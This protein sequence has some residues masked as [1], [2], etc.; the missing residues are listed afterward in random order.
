VKERD[1]LDV[2]RGVCSMTRDETT[3]LDEIIGDFDPT[4][5][6]EKTRLT[7]QIAIWLTEEDKA[8]YDK[9]NRKREF[10]KVARK[11]LQAVMKR[12]AIKVG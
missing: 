11:A 8:L 3:V 6:E 1:P 4:E 2:G 7:K 9:L 12:A 10:T 5:P